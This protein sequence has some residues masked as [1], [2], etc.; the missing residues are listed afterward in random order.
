MALGKTRLYGFEIQA[1]FLAYVE[2]GRR[3]FFKQLYYLQKVRLALLIEENSRVI[4]HIVEEL[5]LEKDGSGDA[6]DVVFVGNEGV[7]CC[8]P[9]RKGVEVVVV[10]HCLFQ[11]LQKLIY[12]VHKF[13]HS[14]G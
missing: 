4:K 2:G 10:D 13:T 11:N 7:V 1:K 14:A 12:A 5:V 9:L 3:F 6:Q 8:L